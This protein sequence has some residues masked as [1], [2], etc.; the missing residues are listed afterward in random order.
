MGRKI[1]NIRRIRVRNRNRNLRQREKFK[2]LQ[3]RLKLVSKSAKQ[4]SLFNFVKRHLP[5]M[6]TELRKW[7]IAFLKGFRDDR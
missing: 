2:L 7:H 5:A 4:I 1:K 3:Q 6:A